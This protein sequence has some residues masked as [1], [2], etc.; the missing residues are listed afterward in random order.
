MLSL[1]KSC[2]VQKRDLTSVKEVA[3][4]KQLY[5]ELCPKETI[6][7]TLSSWM[8][9]NWNRLDRPVKTESLYS[10]LT[11]IL[12]KILLRASLQR[13]SMTWMQSRYGSLR[14]FHSRNGQSLNG[15]KWSQAVTSSHTNSYSRGHKGIRFSQWARCWFSLPNPMYMCLSS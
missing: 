15:Y 10:C 5:F 7:H 13:R 9:P 1:W 8:F 14:S 3:F 2:T 11:H 4:W 6:I 12:Y